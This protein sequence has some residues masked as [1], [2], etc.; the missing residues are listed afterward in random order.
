MIATLTHPQTRF[1]NVAEYAYDLYRLHCYKEALQ[2]FIEAEKQGYGSGWMW[3]GKA[4]ALMALHRYPEA[5]SAFDRALQSGFVRSWIYEQQGKALS[6]IHHYEEARDA[7]HQALHLLETGWAYAHRGSTNYMLGRY[8]EAVR[9][10]DQAQQLGCTW[11]WIERER[12]SAQD[13]LDNAPIWASYR[14]SEVL[15]LVR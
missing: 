11:R 9:D 14:A 1:S 12:S 2:A 13:W 3:A 10:F 5:A 8:E 4:K 6:M 7:F 15:M